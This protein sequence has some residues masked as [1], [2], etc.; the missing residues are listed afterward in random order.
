[1]ESRQRLGNRLFTMSI[2]MCSLDSRVKGEHKRNIPPNITHCSSSHAFDEV[3]NTLRTVALVAEMST[4]TRI[5]QE[6]IFPTRK[7]SASMMR[8]SLSN[9]AI[10]VLSW[11]APADPARACA[12]ILARLRSKDLVGA[13]RQ[14]QL[15]V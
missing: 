12:G 2:R 13:E 10:A 9:A 15:E 6:S 14:R 11:S 4:T 1:M 8:E 7:L 5:N 3:S